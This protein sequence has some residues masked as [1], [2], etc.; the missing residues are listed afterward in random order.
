MAL[1]RSIPVFKVGYINETITIFKMTRPEDFDLPS[2]YPTVSQRDSL[3]VETRTR[4]ASIGRSYVDHLRQ[5][6]VGQINLTDGFRG[7][8][9][10]FR[11][12]DRLEEHI[13]VDG[14]KPNVVILCPCW[15]DFP[16]MQGRSY[17][18]D[19][20]EWFE[21]T[22]N[23][24]GDIK[25]YN[26]ILRAHPAEYQWTNT[27]SLRSLTNRPL[28]AGVYVW[29]ED[30]DGTALEG[31]ADYIVT[32]AGSSGIEYTAIG[33]TILAASQTHYSS[34]GFCH[35][36]Y[37]SEEYLD[38]LGEIGRLAAPS[39]KQQEDAS[40]FAALTLTGGTYAYPWGARSYRLWPGLPS[41]VQRNK[42][43]IDKEIRL[44]SRWLESGTHSYNVFKGLNPDLWDQ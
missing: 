33:K 5:G 27:I 17:F 32:C 13:G 3:T 40:I 7:G 25:D 30:V 2:E 11:E 21:L 10:I 23:T 22:L 44:M 8:D 26:W 15:P 34:W 39:P 24:I 43:N 19:Y 31:F 41:F 37:T 29:P 18:T 35:Q 42:T 28:P 9:E 12:R 36:A 4:L 16:H 38:A 1:R 20:R 6:K 14:R